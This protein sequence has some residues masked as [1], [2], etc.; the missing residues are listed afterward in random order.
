[1]AVIEN[2]VC[3]IGAGICG[4]LLAQKLKRLKPS[5]S[6]ALIDAGR[7][8]F[9]VDARMARRQRL[10]DYNESAW[11]HDYVDELL[12]ENGESQTMAVG[13]WALH[14]EGGCPRFS[15]EDLRLAS[16]YGF[17]VD[18][19]LSWRE[20]EAHYC[21][22]ERAMGISGDPS[23]YPEDGQSV[24][25]PMPGMP[26]SYTLSKVRNWVEASDL[27]TSVMPSARNTRRYDGRPE[28]RRCDTCT[29]I[30]PIGARYSPDFTVRDMVAKKD[31]AL[32]SNTLI[33]RL[34]VD[35]SSNRIT[36]ATEFASARLKHLWSFGPRCSC[37]PWA[38]IGHRIC[39]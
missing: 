25:Y 13:G 35:P 33:R 28:C 20:M 27:K 24:P 14:W 12:V 6:V 36:A 8:I 15:E 37:W 30:C 1:M 10:L 38:S 9:D 4:V 22:A 7:E 3:V 34:I 31:V 19:P 17:G 18:W 23:P 39:F 11:P 26:L 32:Y 5:A 21:E 2:D 16:L 29:P